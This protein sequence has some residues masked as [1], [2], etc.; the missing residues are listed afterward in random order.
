[1]CGSFSTDEGAIAD[2]TRHVAGVEIHTETRARVRPTNTV[3][4]VCPGSRQVDAPWG[5]NPPWAKQLLI[6]ARIEDVLQRKSWKGPF[7]QLRCL[8]PITGWY[9]KSDYD[10]RMYWLRL[11]EASVALMAAFI[12]ED[13]D[14]Q[15]L[16]TMTG[17]PN[18]ECREIKSRMPQLVAPDCTET[19]L[20][21]EP[22]RAL[23][24]ATPWPSGTVKRKV[25]V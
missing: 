3:A 25:L 21:G 18:D 8:V 1:M 22:E 9:E 14:G 20:T 17:Q 4:T 15:H 12:I 10:G 16:V 19:W 2:F 24:V 11:S 7:S 23:A 5:Y 6:N 13:G